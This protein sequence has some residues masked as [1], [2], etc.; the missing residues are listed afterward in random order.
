M[1]ARFTRAELD[2]DLTWTD[3]FGLALL[4]G[5]GFTV[6]LLISE[7]A[8]GYGTERNSNVKL[9]V[10]VG[11]LLASLLAAIVLRIRNA[12]YRRVEVLETADRDHDGIPDVYETKDSP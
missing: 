1:V 2:E 3:V 12:H 8:F 11:S 6:S 7:L 5:V 10:L 9:A 4:A